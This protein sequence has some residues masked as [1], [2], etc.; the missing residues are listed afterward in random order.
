MLASTAPPIVPGPDRQC[1]DWKAD[2][3]NVRGKGD[4]ER[5]A[6]ITEHARDEVER[7]LAARTDDPP[8]PQLPPGAARKAPDRSGRRGCVCTARRRPSDRE[9][10]PA[11]VPA[12]GGDDRAGGVG[13][14]EA[15]REFLGHDGLGFVAGHT[16]RQPASA[17]GGGCRA[18]TARGLASCERLARSCRHLRAVVHASF[19]FVAWPCRSYWRASR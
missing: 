9:A 13:R 15:H 17:C 11:P 4:V 8:L 19:R 18:P 2:R 14:S 3:V 1:A 7:Y 16:E 10:P 5:S 12:R 6:V